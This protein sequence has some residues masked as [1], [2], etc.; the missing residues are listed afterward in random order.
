[1]LR[2]VIILSRYV[3]L[4]CAEKHHHI[5]KPD[6]SASAN[7]PEDYVGMPGAEDRGY[8]LPGSL[9]KPLPEETPRTESQPVDTP[10]THD[11]RTSS[12]P[13]K[14]DLSYMI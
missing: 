7:R 12:G 13:N 5:I 11:S 6:D 10:I 1:V 4:I 9:G 14:V 3:S 2:G 8:M